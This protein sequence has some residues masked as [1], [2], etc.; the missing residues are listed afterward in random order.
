MEITAAQVNELRKVTGAGMMDCKKALT[1]AEGDMAKAVEVLRKKGAAVAAKRAEKTAK[2]GI[3][4]TKVSDDRKS[5]V[6]VEV[7][8]ETDFVAKS[9]DFIALANTIVEAVFTVKPASVEELIEKSAGLQ[10]KINDVLAKIGEKIEVSRF[11]IENSENG[12]V[13]DYIHPGSKL[14][15]LVQFDGVADD[16]KEAFA[17]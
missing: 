3:V 5:A 12:I 16:K 10:E 1:E 15:I 11:A 6:V 7:N 13:V 2:E 14:A 9:D 8:C 4:L 17:V